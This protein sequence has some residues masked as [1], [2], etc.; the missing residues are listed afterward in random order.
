MLIHTKPFENNFWLNSGVGM[1]TRFAVPYFFAISGYFLASKFRG[2]QPNRWKILKAYLF[3]LLRFYVIWFVFLRTVDI[4][5]GGS[6]I[7]TIGYYIK[8]FFFTTDGSALWF[9]EALIW[10][11]VIVTVLTRRLNARTVFSIGIAFLIIG[12]CFSTLLGV[13]GEWEII[14]ALKPIVTYTGIQGPLFFAFPYVAMGF[15]M[16]EHN[17]KPA[18]RRDLVCILL[19]FACLGAESLLMVTKLYAP[20]TFLWISALPMTWFVLRLSVTLSVENK[21]FHYVLRKISTL[22]YVLHVI[23]LKIL[24]YV[25]KNAGIQYSAHLLLTAL[26]IVITIVL[27]YGIYE[28][29]K[30]KTFSW[31]KYVM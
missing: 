6:I 2:G 1:I 24:K 21:P 13:T 8:Q 30:R 7:H 4:T 25:F 14:K 15:L 10:A 20:L 17:L 26:T 28:L 29:S 16:A 31:L 11:S 9:V 27:S 18:N 3:R 23:V 19:F 12:Y 5:V 22:C